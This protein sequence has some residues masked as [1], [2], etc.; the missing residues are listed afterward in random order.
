MTGCKGLHDWHLL[1]LRHQPWEVFLLAAWDIAS[2]VRG[3]FFIGM[4]FLT[5]SALL[6]GVCLVIMPDDPDCHLLTH[7]LTV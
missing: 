2:R 4:P 3:A 1:W 7:W 6:K 5:S